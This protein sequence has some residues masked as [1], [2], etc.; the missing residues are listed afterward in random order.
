MVGSPGR[1]RAGG[2]DRVPSGRGPALPP[3]PR[4]LPALRQ[5]PAAQALRHGAFNYLLK[6]CNI[7]EMKLTIERGLEKK[8]LSEALRE[9]V[10]ELEEANNTIQTFNR[11]LEDRVN[12]ATAELAQ[13][14]VADDPPPALASPDGLR[15]APLLA[16]RALRGRH[17]AFKRRRLPEGEK[18]C[19]QG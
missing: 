10:I 15:Y 17:A 8:R 11:Q 18:N 3:E 7:D 14:F 5:A 19:L 4:E 6:P 12:Q 2:A 16:Y 1:R 13:R 9:R